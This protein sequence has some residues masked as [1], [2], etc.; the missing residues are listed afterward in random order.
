MAGRKE[1][2]CLHFQIKGCYSTHEPVIHKAS[3]ACKHRIYKS[4]QI[5]LQLIHRCLLVSTVDIARTD[6]PLQSTGQTTGQFTYIVCTIINN[7]N[8][9]RTTFNVYICTRY[10]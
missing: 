1:K 7:C 5:A 9:M 3:D 8:Y 4:V 6:S 2:L 10:L